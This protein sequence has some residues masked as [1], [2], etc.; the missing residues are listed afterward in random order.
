MIAECAL[1]TGFPHGFLSC[2]EL[3]LADR[4]WGESKRWLSR[5]VADIIKCNSEG[6]ELV[7]CH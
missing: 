3:L 6:A 7:V 5:F 4:Q 2:L 1:R